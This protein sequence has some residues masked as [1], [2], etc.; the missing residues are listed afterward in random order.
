MAKKKYLPHFESEE[1]ELEFWKTHRIED[2]ESEPV[3]D[4]SWDIRG[5]KK[6]RV[7]LRLEPTLI[8]QLKRFAEDV[9]VPYQ[10]LTRE[11]IRRGLWQ[12]KREREMREE[13]LAEVED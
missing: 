2:Y 6:K 13:Q 7:T 10:T 8:A 1:E 4:I 9:D 12:A 3:Y 5:E 11:L